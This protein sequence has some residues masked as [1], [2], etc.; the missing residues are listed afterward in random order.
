M[1]I[2]LIIASVILVVLVVWII[3][4]PTKPPSHKKKPS[5]TCTIKT[6]T[7]H[8]S[9]PSSASISKVIQTMSAH[10]CENLQDVSESSLDISNKR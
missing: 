2:F 1:L 9:S 7:K 4:T 5:N 10:T 6:S 3:K 8:K